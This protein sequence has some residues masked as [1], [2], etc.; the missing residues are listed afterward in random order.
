VTRPAP[1]H[2]NPLPGWPCIERGSQLSPKARQISS[3]DSPGCLHECKGAGN[4]AAPWLQ[5]EPEAFCLLLPTA[6]ARRKAAC[7]CLRPLREGHRL[8][9]SGCTHED[10]QPWTT[11]LHHPC[12]REK[13]VFS[14][15]ETGIRAH[16]GL[17][18]PLQALN[19]GI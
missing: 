5:Q 18:F 4:L 14:P 10:R 7:S 13:K 12:E 6:A 8:P 1:S 3:W 9:R 17:I 19:A 15:P 2:P 16:T 11:L